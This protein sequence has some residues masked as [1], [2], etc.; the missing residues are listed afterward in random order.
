MQSGRMSYTDIESGTEREVPRLQGSIFGGGGSLDR[1]CPS[2]ERRSTS[3]V[4][5]HTAI[6]EGWAI[7]SVLNESSLD[8]IPVIGKDHGYRD[9]GSDVVG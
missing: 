6:R 7:R 8:V 3:E 4:V 5:R 1:A 9:Y 2:L